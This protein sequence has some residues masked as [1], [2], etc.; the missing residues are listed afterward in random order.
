MQP[1]LS[2]VAVLGFAEA[3]ALFRALSVT[4]FIFGMIF[5]SLLCHD[6]G[7]AEHHL[8]ACSCTHGQN[9]GP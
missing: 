3:D 1:M 2:P 4:A 5:H 9:G 7:D 6:K 8:R